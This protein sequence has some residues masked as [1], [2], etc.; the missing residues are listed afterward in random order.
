MPD[1]AALKIINMNV[2]SMQAVKED[3]NTNIGNA[4]ESNTPQGSTCGGE[5]LHKHRCQ[6]KS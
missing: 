2:D 6:F 4:K 3:C 5:E 1:T